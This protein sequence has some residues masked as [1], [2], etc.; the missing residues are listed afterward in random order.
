MGSSE[1]TPNTVT[2]NHSHNN[3]NNNNN[4]NANQE[5]YR[6]VNTK[7]GSHQDQERSL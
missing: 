3:N 7:P 5:H 2:A 1:T 4:H 6:G